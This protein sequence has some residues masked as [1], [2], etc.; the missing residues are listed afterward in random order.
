MGRRAV[1]A[2][3]LNMCACLHV[4]VFVVPQGKKVRKSVSDVHVTAP[5][6][7]PQTVPV[8]A[9]ALLLSRFLVCS[10]FIAVIKSAKIYVGSVMCVSVIF[11]PPRRFFLNLFIFHEREGAQPLIVTS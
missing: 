8:L 11:S 1:V 2:F 3:F 9:S 10:G 6:T 4:F 7:P 5:T